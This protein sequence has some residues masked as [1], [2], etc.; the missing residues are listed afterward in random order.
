MSTFAE[1]LLISKIEKERMLRKLS[2]IQYMGLGDGVEQVCSVTVATK[3]HYLADYTLG[4]ISDC[5]PN[6]CKLNH[7]PTIS[8][9]SAVI[10]ALFCLIKKLILR[11]KEPFRMVQTSVAFCWLWKCTEIVKHCVTAHRGLDQRQHFPVS[12]QQF[13]W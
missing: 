11:A 13:K 4:R 7:S 2:E 12:D 10:T 5:S 6:L 1:L 3:T 8:L 9:L